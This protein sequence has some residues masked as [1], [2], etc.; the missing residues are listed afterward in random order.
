MVTETSIESAL[1]LPPEL[2][3]LAELIRL[4]KKP[5]IDFSFRPQSMGERI[6]W[7]GTQVE[8]LF[9]DPPDL[10][11][12]IKRAGV[13]QAPSA[14]IT[15]AQLAG[16]GIRLIVLSESAISQDVS[17]VVGEGLRYKE[18]VLSQQ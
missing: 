11:F 5:N 8:F 4:G 7:G 6:G 12:S 1:A 17:H 18:G 13:A 3:V 9:S 15:K 10:A 14:I 2:M 16:Q